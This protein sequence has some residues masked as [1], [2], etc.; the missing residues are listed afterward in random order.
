MSALRNAVRG[1]CCTSGEELWQ[2]LAY[3]QFSIHCSSRATAAVRAYADE[4]ARTTDSASQRAQTRQLTY[5]PDVVAAVRD[6]LPPGTVVDGELVVWDTKSGRTM[7]PALLGRITAGR[8][9]SREAAARPASLVVFDVL[10]D[11]GSDGV[12]RRTG[13]DRGR[14]QHHRD[15][16]DSYRLAHAHQKTFATTAD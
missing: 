1:S 16:H 4:L 8:R 11:A 6:S 9:L 12:V 5:F 10:A 7:F 2:K 13:G 15:R 14:G 3:S